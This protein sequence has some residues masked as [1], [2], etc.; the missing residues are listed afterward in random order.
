MLPSEWADQSNS[1]LCIWHVGITAMGTIYYSAI[2]QNIGHV[3]LCVKP[4]F[5]TYTHPPPNKCPFHCVLH[6]ILDV[7]SQNVAYEYCTR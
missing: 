3:A 5:W 1:V 4:V 6:C 7:G 2:Y